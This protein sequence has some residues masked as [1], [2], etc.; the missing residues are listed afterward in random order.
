VF[1]AARAGHPVACELVDE[2]VDHVAM[3][4]VDLAAV[5]DPERVVLDGSMGRALVP[6]LPRLR[7]LVAASVLFAP[8]LSVS[9]LV[10]SAALAGA[11][12]EAWRL[13]RG[14]ALPEER[15]DR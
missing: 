14:S 3:T 2:V 15:E 8:T 7:E 12:G 6:F 9:E 13:V 1:A 5:L 10:P 4:I 11:V